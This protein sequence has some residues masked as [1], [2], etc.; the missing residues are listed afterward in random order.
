MLIGF[1][2]FQPHF[3]STLYACRSFTF[4]TTFYAY[5]ISTFTT[6]FLAYRIFTFASTFYVYGI[7]TFT[8]TF[9]ADRIFTF[10]TTFYIHILHFSFP[11]ISWQVFY[12]N[13]SIPLLSARFPVP[14]PCIIVLRNVC[15]HYNHPLEYLS[16]WGHL[17]RRITKKERNLYNYFEIVSES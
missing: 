7:Y 13:Y 9:Y 11:N 6:T 8:T 12:K 3:T 17:I 14:F 1:S 4:T 10:T 2:H 15:L 16:K 5:R